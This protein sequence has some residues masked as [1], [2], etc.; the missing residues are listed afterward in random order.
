KLP[1]GGNDL[2]QNLWNFW[3]W[4]RQLTEGLSPYHTDLLFYPRGA[5]LAFHTHSEANIIAT[6]PI[7]VTLGPAAALNVATLAGFVIAGVGGYLLSR[8]L[9]GD[10]RAAFI[11]GAIFAFFPQH[12]EQSLEHLNLASYGF[13][14]IAAACLWRALRTGC[15]GMWGAFA[16]ALLVNSLFSWHNSILV[17]PVLALI[18]ARFLVVGERPRGRIVLETAIAALV[19][20]AL[21][22]PFAWPMLSAAWSGEG[23]WAK[24]PVEK[25]I[26]LLFIVIPAP[27]H[28]LWGSFVDDLYERFRSYRSV[29][30]VGYV[31]LATLALALGAWT[32][33]GRRRFAGLLFWTIAAGVMLLLSLGDELRV[34][35]TRTG[36]PL[37]FRVVREIPFLDTSRLAHRYLVPGMLALSAIAGAGAAAILARTRRPGIVSVALLAVI[38]VDFLAAPFPLRDVPRPEWTAEIARAPEGAVLSIPGGYRARAAE[39]MYFQTLHGRPIIG[40]YV[41]VTPPSIETLLERFPFLRIIQEGRPEVEMRASE[42]L[43]PILAD[44][45]IGVV[46]LHRGRVREDLAAAQAEHAG[47]QKERLYNPERGIPRA[48]F[49][50]IRDVLRSEWGDPYHVDPDVEL[51]ARPAP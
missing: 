18:V 34:A 46:V 1:A 41:S 49:D 37:P 28:P 43:P 6:W 11:A 42:G 20:F 2:F 23:T 33:G 31:G 17:S 21:H 32:L 16:V 13:M 26:D 3:F 24:P 38:A 10:R 14:A 51:Y 9:W 35:G 12:V 29:G 39:D 15:P 44:L 50:E 47:T 4:K 19:T 27:F 36:I 40:G 8:E 22:V 48:M 5:S 45:P 30:F 7:L 25:P